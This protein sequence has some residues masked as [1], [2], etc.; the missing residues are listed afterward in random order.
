MSNNSMKQDQV[1][2]AS[3]ERSTKKSFIVNLN[4]LL[5]LKIK[6]ENEFIFTLKNDVEIKIKEQNIKE[7]EKSLNQLSKEYGY[8]NYLDIFLKS[9]QEITNQNNETEVF[10]VIISIPN[11]KVVFDLEDEADGCIVMF[12][13]NENITLSDTTENIYKKIL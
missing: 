7:L 13:N 5:Y 8:K 12:E 11:I 1:F 6:N 9:K 2:Y 3:S 4:E 10:D